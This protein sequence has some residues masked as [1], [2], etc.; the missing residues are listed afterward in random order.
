MMYLTR[1]NMRNYLYS[2]MLTAVIAATLPTTANATESEPT[3]SL[4]ADDCGVTLSVTQS[5]VVVEGAAGMTLEVV[6]LTGRP[7]MKV[8]IDS[9]SQKID[10]NLPKGCYIFKI[11]KVVRKVSIA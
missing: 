4:T 8:R 10:L 6:S 2:I 11:D 9:Q 7:V 3:T 5:A 1:N